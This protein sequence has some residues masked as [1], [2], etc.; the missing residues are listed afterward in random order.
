[1]FRKCLWDYEVE[2]NVEHIAEHGLTPEDVE[3]AFEDLLRETV[4][5]SS[6]RPAIYGLA[7]DGRTIFVV[8]EVIDDDLIYVTTAFEPGE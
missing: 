8:F 6:G 1:M 7:L 3:N 5:R 4:S 2:G